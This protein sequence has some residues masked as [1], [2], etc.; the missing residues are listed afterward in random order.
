VISDEIRSLNQDFTC[1]IIDANMYGL[2]PSWKTESLSSAD[3][4]PS[5]SARK[6]RVCQ[7]YELVVKINEI[8]TIA[9]D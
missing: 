6:E 1:M 3:K 2:I 7:S 5:S 9:V 8:Y 4:S